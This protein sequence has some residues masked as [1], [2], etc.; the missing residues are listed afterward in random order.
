MNFEEEEA[1]LNTPEQR[2]K[3][4]CLKVA[5]LR[6]QLK[7]CKSLY[8]ASVKKVE[9]LSSEVSALKHDIERYVEI[10]AEIATENAQLE[11]R[12]KLAFDMMKKHGID[13]AAIMKHINSLM[14]RVSEEHNNLTDVQHNNL[15]TVADSASEG[16]A[17]DEDNWICPKCKRPN[18]PTNKSC[19][20]LH[21]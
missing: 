21:E 18:P 10:N 15:K 14:E 16:H 3:R 12:L 5:E 17:T 4:L 8:N 9:S 20:W 19:G 7:G 11:N 6:E 1:K 2:T 13:N